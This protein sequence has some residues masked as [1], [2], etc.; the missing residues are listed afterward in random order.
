MKIQIVSPRSTPKN[1][2]LIVAGLAL[3]IHCH[4]AAAVGTWTPVATNA[5]AGG[6]HM[7]LLSDGT[8]MVQH[9]DDT[10]PNTMIWYRLT[11]GNQGG[12]TNGSWTTIAPSHMSHVFYE[13]FV[14]PDGRVVVAGGEYGTG[15]NHA[16][17]YD[18][19][20][21]FWTTPLASPAPIIRDGCSELLPDGRL[22]VFPNTYVFTPPFTNMIYDPT[23][24]SWSL[25]SPCLASQDEATWIKLPDDSILTIDRNANTTERYIPALNQW[26]ADAPVPPNSQV[27][28]NVEIGA[29]LLLPNGKA[30]FLGASGRTALYTPSGTTNAGTWASGANI[31]NGLVTQDA[32]AAML[33]NGKILCVVHTFGSN[34]SGPSYFYEYDYVANSFTQVNSPTGGLTDSKGANRISLLDLPDGTVLFSDTTSQ[35]H[36]YQPTCC[37]LAA[38][39]PVINTISANADGSYL[40]TGT[41]LNGISAGAAYGDNAQMNSNYPL[42]RLTD[43]SGNVYY[44]RTYNW[45]STGVMTGNR[46]VSTRFALPAAVFQGGGGTFSLVAVANGISSDPVS[47]AGP[48]WV[49]FNYS[50]FFQFGTYDFPFSTLAQGTNAVSSGGSILIK[51]NGTSS[52]TLTIKKSLTIV[53]IGGPAT[54]GKQ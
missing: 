3:L 32:P 22:L 52:E 47:F 39:K 40:L 9:A 45:S 1:K 17:V 21:N 54:V 2:V 18:P 27:W 33:A 20:A 42:V 19:V 12:Y 4:T 11:P 5:P 44:A 50:G 16:E 30:F 23:A 37:P 36:V 53:A 8:V 35:L 34:N 38:G 14:L 25:G 15:T 24:N 10:L 7:L 13:S 26:I 6:A 48:V 46:V 41:G 43:G 31:P 51:G 28:S 29:A 49:D